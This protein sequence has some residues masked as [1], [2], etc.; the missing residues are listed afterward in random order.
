MFLL[1]FFKNFNF[2]LCNFSVRTLKCKKKYFFK[3]FAHEKLKKPP[4]KVA[5]NLPRPL[6]PTV[7]PRHQ[8]TAQN[9]FSILRNFGTRHLFSYLWSGSGRTRTKAQKKILIQKWLR[10]INLQEKL[11]NKCLYWKT[12]N[13]IWNQKVQVRIRFGSY[14]DL[15]EPKPKPKKD[16]D[17]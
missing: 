16:P 2:V 11:P 4:K 1:F 8:P 6:F 7:Q 15:V 10:C 12:P 14:P 9:W 3:F 17:T 13:L 5:Q